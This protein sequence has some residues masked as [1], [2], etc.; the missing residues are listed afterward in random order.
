MQ[1]LFWTPH[2]DCHPTPGVGKGDLIP[3]FVD[4]VLGRGQPD[5]TEDEVFAAVAVCLA[6]DRASVE[7]G[8]VK[9]NYL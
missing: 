7:H 9:V 4:A 6:I 3:A 8:A 1:V 5:V 2:F